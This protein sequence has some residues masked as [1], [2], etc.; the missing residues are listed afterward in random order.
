MRLRS[1]HPIDH[2]SRP[3]N[4]VPAADAYG[5]SAC[6]CLVPLPECSTDFDSTLHRGETILKS[7]ATFGAAAAVAAIAVA[8]A[9]APQSQTSG[10]ASNADIMESNAPANNTPS[11][12]T[13]DTDATPQSISQA[14]HK[15]ASDKQLTGDDKT[16]FI[17]NCKQGKTTREGQ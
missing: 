2:C 17:K 10:S 4:Q 5:H 3:A 6:S 7:I 16:N 1:L 9:Q 11:K 12:A 13:D 14:C 8:F 15:Q